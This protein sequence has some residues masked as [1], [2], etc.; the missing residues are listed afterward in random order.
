MNGP[1]NIHELK[2]LPG[3]LAY[4]NKFISNLVG[5]CQPFSCL[6]KK[7]VLFECDESRKNACES[8]KSYLIKPPYWLLCPLTIYVTTLDY[9]FGVLLAQDND[10]EKETAI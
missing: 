7:G 2:I 1:Q 4:I 3:K 9:F 5:L 8:I 10:Y 6:M